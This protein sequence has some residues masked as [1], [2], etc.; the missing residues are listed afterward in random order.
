M[1]DLSRLMQI[2]TV[3]MLNLNLNLNLEADSYA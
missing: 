3:M 1:F 2:I